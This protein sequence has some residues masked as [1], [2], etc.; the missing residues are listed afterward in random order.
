MIVESSRQT[1]VDEREGNVRKIL[2]LTPSRSPKQ[3]FSKNNNQVREKF[4]QV[5]L[6]IE[7]DEP[8]KGESRYQSIEFRR[9]QMF[10]QVE[11]TTMIF[12]NNRRG[13]RI[14]VDGSKCNVEHKRLSRYLTIISKIKRVYPF[15]LFI[16]DEILDV[17]RG[18][19][20]MKEES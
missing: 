13:E 9:D 18:D 7:L 11:K 19:Q 14:D 5:L 6:L 10:T 1:C 16:S 3:I 8:E 2:V 4:A 20:L 15:N 12:N 17:K